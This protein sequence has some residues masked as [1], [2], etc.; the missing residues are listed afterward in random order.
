M[1]AERTSVA[2][3]ADDGLTY[4]TVTMIESGH[5]LRHAR[6]KNAHFC[7]DEK[8]MLAATPAHSPHEQ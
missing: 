4:F 7:R 8:A 1:P 3:P 6:H 5:A 2:P